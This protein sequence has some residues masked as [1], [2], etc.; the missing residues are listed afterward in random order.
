M[1]GTIK[2]FNQ[3]KGYGF[4]KREDSKGDVFVHHTSCSRAEKEQ[5]KEGTRVEF[6]IEQGTKGPF[7]VNLKLA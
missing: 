2:W 5:L 7:A 1:F 6:E 3:T 4:I